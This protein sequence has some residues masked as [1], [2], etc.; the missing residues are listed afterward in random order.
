MFK[1]LFSAPLFYWIFFISVLNYCFPMSWNFVLF[2][3]LNSYLFLFLKLLC[4]RLLW[5]F[6]PPWSLLFEISVFVFPLKTVLFEVL[7]TAFL[8]N[9]LHFSL[10]WNRSTWNWNSRFCLIILYWLCV[11]FAKN[12]SFPGDTTNYVCFL[13]KQ[14]CCFLLILLCLFHVGG[15]CVCFL[16]E[17]CVS[18]VVLA[19]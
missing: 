16:F 18:L 5:F 14:L 2:S 12:V 10:V 17:T 8:L 15:C 7:T 13:F 6:Q 11:M 3:V 1:L 19:H 4:L 9:L